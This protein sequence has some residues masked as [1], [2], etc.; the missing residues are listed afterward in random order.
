[1]RYLAALDYQHLDNGMFLTSLAQ[2]ISK[3]ENVQPIIIHGDSEYTERVIQT[4][5]MREDA[6][7]RSIKD[8]N[9]RLIALLADEGISAIG[10]NGYQ[11]ELI[12]IKENALHL[13]QSYFES[14]P[15]EPVLVI[16]SLVLNSSTHDIM[17]LSLPTMAAFLYDAMSA[18]ELFIFSRSE[19]DEIM[20]TEEIPAQISAS[21]L[22]STFWD[23]K[24]PAEFHQFAQ[25]MRFTT[26]QK[27]HKIP[28]LSSTMLISP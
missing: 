21:N 16:S 9:H 3:Q 1:M 5:V 27:F 8:L 4:G 14:L 23:D 13:D 25:P 2:A 19:T 22:E 7:I 6:K 18:E 26:A 24:I 20:E 15:K 28:D 17:P 11:R 12:T 10:I